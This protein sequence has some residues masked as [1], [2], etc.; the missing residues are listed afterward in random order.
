M[1]W[2]S[3]PSQKSEEKRIF[4]KFL[5]FPKCI[6]NKWRWLETATYESKYSC[7]WGDCSWTDTRWIDEKDEKICSSCLG[8]GLCHECKGTCTTTFI[9][10]IKK[11]DEK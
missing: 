10:K 4:R 5:I 11:G 6:N 3:K 8:V 1:K 9:D 7:G 2:L